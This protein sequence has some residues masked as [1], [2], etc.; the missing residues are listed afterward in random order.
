[1]PVSRQRK[2]NRA[3]KRPRVASSAAGSAQPQ[4]RKVLNL[5]IVAIILI[6]AAAASVVAYVVVRKSQAGTEVTTPSGLKYTDLKVGDGLSPKVG[7]TV[8]VHYIGWLENGKEFNNSKGGPPVEFTLGP[9]LIPGWNEAL[10]TMK[11]G[12]KRRLV[13]PPKLA[14]G[15]SGRPPNIPP[16]ATLT[17]EIEL[18]GVK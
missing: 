5:K 7:Q 16:N 10:P 2:P 15:A 1:M 9:G 17:F 3:R 6:V 13:I 14:Y 4:T 11:V 12:G 8:R 18:L